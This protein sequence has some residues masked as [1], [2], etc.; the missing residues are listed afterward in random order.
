[1]D[2]V[3][4]IIKMH[5]GMLR[6]AAAT[7]V[8]YTMLLAKQGWRANFS[9]PLI[10]GRTIKL[11][12]ALEGALGRPAPKD[13]RR[14]R[15]LVKIEKR[16]EPKPEP[17]ADKDGAGGAKEGAEGTLE[18]GGKGAS[19]SD[20]AAEA[21]ARGVP[22]EV[23]TLPRA[24]RRSIEDAML[25]MLA[26]HDV[27]KIQIPDPA[28]LERRAELVN[29]MYELWHVTPRADKDLLS[30]TTQVG[31][32]MAALTN[33]H[34]ETDVFFYN[35]I[36]IA[37]GSKVVLRCLHLLSVD[38]A[39]DMLMHVLR[40]LLPLAYYLANNK[41]AAGMELEVQLLVKLVYTMDLVQLLAVLQ[42]LTSTYSDG[43]LHLLMCTKLGALALA[44]LLR[45]GHE[46]YM[47]DETL[48]TAQDNEQLM[49]W[50]A[51]CQKLTVRML[52][53]LDALFIA[54]TQGTNTALPPAMITDSEILVDLV[55]E[56]GANANVEQ[57]NQISQ[58]LAACALRTGSQEVQ[59]QVSQLLLSLNW[60]A[61]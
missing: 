25:K 21:E 27:D 48:R 56:L 30:N 11:S 38:R 31:A 1:M 39:Q 7:D 44:A 18:G 28:T 3:N 22:A 58:Q 53:G 47:K 40:C 52:G 17:A 9:G 13:L 26:I 4:F 43:G 59:A 20:E 14:P 55:Y 54:A 15:Q 49:L 12:E 57:R 41:N 5:Q 61:S 35:L 16:E 37:K 50:A 32:D 2:E 10:G 45:R 51:A 6:D 24:V 19:K 60:T 34:N 36:V 23:S 29:Q 42:H 46:E 33:C 8:Y